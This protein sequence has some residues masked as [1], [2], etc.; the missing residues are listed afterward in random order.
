MFE[1]QSWSAITSLCAD[2]ATIITY[3]KTNNSE[4][5]FFA[6]EDAAYLTDGLKVIL[7]NLTGLVIVEVLFL[8]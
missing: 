6:I 1:N 4:E 2:K 7:Q 8:V 3:P 5:N